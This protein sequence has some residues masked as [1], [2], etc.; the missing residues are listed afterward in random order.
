MKIC[1]LGDNG[2]V[3]VQKWVEALHQIDKIELH[4]ITFKKG[5]CLEDVKYHFLD[6]NINFRRDPTF[7]I[8]R[9]M[10]KKIFKLKN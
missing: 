3:H 9:I 5:N 10:K 6:N 4:V 1:L 2:S 7:M 8:T